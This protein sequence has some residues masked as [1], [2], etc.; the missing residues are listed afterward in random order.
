M[1]DDRPAVTDAE[2]AAKAREMR[3]AHQ[4]RRVTGSYTVEKLKD[5]L[6]ELV[7]RQVTPQQNPPK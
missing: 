3:V 1:G 6:F 4:R 2:I 7:D 5:E